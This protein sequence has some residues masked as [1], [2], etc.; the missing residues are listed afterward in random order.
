MTINEEYEIMKR[1][2]RTWNERSNWDSTKYSYHIEHHTAKSKAMFIKLLNK[3][4]EKMNFDIRHGFISTE[5]F[6]KLWK[7]WNDCSRSISNMTII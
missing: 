4:F 7:V 3:D 2:L 6:N 5:K 1:E